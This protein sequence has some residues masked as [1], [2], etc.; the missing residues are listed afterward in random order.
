ML[1]NFSIFRAYGKNGTCAM[2][3][4]TIP[5]SEY[6]MKFKKNLCYHVEC[7]NCCTCKSSF[8]VGDKFVMI[9]EK[10]IYCIEDYQK[11]EKNRLVIAEEEKS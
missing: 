1:S 6:A 9:T 3:G 4:E 11:T 5:A 10:E 7:F 8:C 2:C